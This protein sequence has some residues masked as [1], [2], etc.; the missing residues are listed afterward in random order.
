MPREIKIFSMS[1]LDLLCCALGGVILLS[2]LMI[3]S[4]QQVATEGVK[5]TYFNCRA[6]VWAEVDP[7]GLTGDRPLAPGGRLDGAAID[8]V[9]LRKRVAE[10]DF[11]LQLLYH[12]LFGPGTGA[13][14]TE[15]SDR[16][17]A[18][19]A[20]RVTAASTGAARVAKLNGAPVTTQGD[21]FGKERLHYDGSGRLWYPF[22][23]SA[24]GGGVPHGY[25]FFV[26]RAGR[27]H[28]AWGG[29]PPEERVRCRMEL[30]GSGVAGR[31]LLQTHPDADMPG[32][33][34]WFDADAVRRAEAALLKKPYARPNAGADEL[35]KAQAA[36]KRMQLP[37][38]YAPAWHTADPGTDPA[39]RAGTAFVFVSR[40][41]HPDGKK[42]EVPWPH[43][44]V[45]HRRGAPW[46][47]PAS[48]PIPYPKGG[49]PRAPESAGGAIR[50]GRLE[51]YPDGGAWYDTYP[52]ALCVTT[53]HP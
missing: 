20:L 13:A 28:P 38:R 7:G 32:P 19:E 16:S 26:L 53:R 24:N 48:F 45:R 12:P 39:G 29:R 36:H 3:V 10:Y 50:W 15:L 42:R 27:L 43:F 21:T 34:V 4:M 1:F 25:Y 31:L 41:V 11:H 40:E 30:S 44:A 2:L 18:L 52:P 17:D 5:Q 33:P 14:A 51:H 46:P 23:L 49:E 35:R 9:E 8:D 47:H 22:E 37:N 6:T